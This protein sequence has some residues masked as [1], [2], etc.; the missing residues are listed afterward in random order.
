MNTSYRQ[1]RMYT[2]ERNKTLTLLTAFGIN[3][4]HHGNMVA[5][6][7]IA[8]SDITIVVPVKNNQIGVSRL[9]DACLKVFVLN[10]CPAEILI[11]DNLSDTPVEVP[12]YLA[13]YLPVRVLFCTRPALLPHATLEHGKLK[14]NGFC[15]WTVIA[16]RRQDS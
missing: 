1:K 6:S 4:T 15:S 7:K 3:P 8:F 12:A 11:V 5:P 14:P 2:K 16:S 9:L 10:H 13:S